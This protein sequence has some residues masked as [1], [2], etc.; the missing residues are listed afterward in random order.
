MENVSNGWAS[1]LEGHVKQMNTVL[2]A[3]LIEM[4]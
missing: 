4:L 1:A 3:I 2:V